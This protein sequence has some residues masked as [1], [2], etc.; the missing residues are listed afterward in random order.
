MSTV[1]V[2]MRNADAVKNALDEFTTRTANKIVKEAVEASWTPFL[3]RA[4][5]TARWAVGGIMG[6]TIANSLEL[7]PFKKQHRGSYGMHVALKPDVEEFVHITKDGKRYYIPSA[8]EYGH[9]F[10]YRGGKRNSPKDVP[11]FP[12]M[13]SSLDETLPDAPRIFEE[14]L[15]KGL[16]E[17]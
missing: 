17:K 13:R 3:K 8:I 16:K 12:F 5:E 9:A 11:A 2:K 6:K 15:E 7:K 1:R 4:I 10:P 14:T